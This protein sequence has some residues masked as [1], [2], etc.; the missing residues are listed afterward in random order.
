MS[1]RSICRIFLKYRSV[2]MKKVYK[3]EVRVTKEE[4]EKYQK[5]AKK[6]T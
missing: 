3:I 2:I 5:L 1:L 6:K 4:K